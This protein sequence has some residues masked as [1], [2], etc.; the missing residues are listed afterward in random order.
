[1]I[2]WVSGSVVAQKSQISGGSYSWVDVT[3]FGATGLICFGLDFGRGWWIDQV[4]VMNLSPTL[5]HSD[6]RYKRDFWDDLPERS[7]Y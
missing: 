3:C 5:S 6:L 4:R 7:L 2:P 1:M